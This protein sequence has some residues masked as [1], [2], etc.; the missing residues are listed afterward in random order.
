M[1]LDRVNGTLLRPGGGEALPLASAE[2]LT[3]NKVE[4]LDIPEHPVGLHLLV[5]TAAGQAILMDDAAY[6]SMELAKLVIDIT[7]SASKIVCEPLPLDDPRQ[8]RPDITVAREKFG[9][10]PVVPLREGLTKTIA[11]FDALLR[12]DA[13]QDESA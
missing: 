9:W 11:Y 1:E 8:R 10:E 5:N 3:D 13:G 7:G 12:G 2:I 6:S 4:R